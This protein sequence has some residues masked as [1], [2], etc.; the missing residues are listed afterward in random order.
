MSR[1]FRFYSEALDDP[2]VQKLDPPTFKAWVNL[3]CLANRNGGFLPPAEDVAF[4]L[5]IDPNGAITLLERLLNATLID[6]VNGGANGYRYAPHGWAERQYKSDTSTDRVKRFRQR[7]KAVTETPPETETETDKTLAK[8]NA[9]SDEQFWESAKAFLHPERKAPGSLIGKW[10]R[11]HGKQETAA[12]ITRAQIERPVQRI[13]FIEGI[14]R[15]QA[16]TYDPD[17]ITV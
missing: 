6:K 1:W 7:S 13:P 11:D 12:A 9:P 4:A 10:C 14:L 2:K 17:R 8:A 15:K 16:K 3:L 5:R